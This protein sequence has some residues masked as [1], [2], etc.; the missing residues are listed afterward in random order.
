[1]RRGGRRR[2]A[3]DRDG[4][5]AAAPSNGHRYHQQN[6]SHNAPDPFTHPG[7]DVKQPSPAAGKLSTNLYRSRFAR[8]SSESRWLQPACRRVT[9]LRRLIFL[10]LACIAAIGVEAGGS[11]Q[12]RP[13]CSGA[14]W[15]TLRDG[16][17][18]CPRYHSLISDYALTHLRW[19]AWN[20][21]EARATGTLSCVH[22]SYCR[23]LRPQRLSIRLS[24]AHVCADGVRIYSRYDQRL[25]PPYAQAGPRRSGYRI[26]CDG[27]TGGG[28]G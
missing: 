15:R 17:Q 14:A 24:R 3:R 11:A 27:M 13:S 6:A 19:T 7:G 26:P 22:H 28:N 8:E 12:A 25:L 5:A 23:G 4:A 9:A 18:V 21:G 10:A 20:A 1:M 16:T 2:G